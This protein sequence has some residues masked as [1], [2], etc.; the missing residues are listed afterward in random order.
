MKDKAFLDSNILIY[1]LI[2]LPKHIQYHQYNPIDQYVNF[3]M[4]EILNEKKE[5][6]GQFH[7][8]R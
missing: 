8:L 1:E 2:G 7:R 4:Y 5:E 6:G 3:D